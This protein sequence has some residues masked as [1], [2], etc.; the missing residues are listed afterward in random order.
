VS[1]PWSKAVGLRIEPGAVRGTLSPS[2]VKRRLSALRGKATPRAECTTIRPDPSMDT[3]AHALDTT[4]L[5]LAGAASLQGASLD[6]EVADSLVHLDVVNGKFGGD[7]D[8]Q[9]QSIALA[10]AVEL[11]GDAV[12]DHDIRWQLQADEKH[13]LIGAMARDLLATVSRAAA[14][15]GLGLHSVQ[16]ELCAQWNRHAGSAFK[17]GSGVFAVI[18]GRQAVIAGVAGGA[19]T[20]LSS[21]LWIDGHDTATTLDSRVDRLLTGAGR[22]P[23]RQSSFVVVT[24]EGSNKSVSPRWTVKQR[25]AAAS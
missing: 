22:D 12:H 23:A 3:L 16:P 20:T 24:S 8:R 18:G 19:I 5:E 11:L 7:S 21:G 1:R 4:M 2:W 9:L 6:V 17:S 10:C 25:Q 13:L 15:H 14:R